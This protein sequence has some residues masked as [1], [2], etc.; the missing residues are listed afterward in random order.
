MKLQL[1]IIFSILV[2]V[3]L[4][5]CQKDS[6]TETNSGEN[7]HPQTDI[8]WPSLTDSPWPMHHGNPQSTG[9]SSTPGPSE[10]IVEWKFEVGYPIGTSI[11]F[12][13]DSTIYFG[14]DGPYLW[15]LNWDGSLKWK[16][17]FEGNY[18]LTCPPLIS[19][20]GTIY[21]GTRSNSL[22]AL[23]RDG[24]I[25][26]KF[27]ADD[28]VNHL[29]MNIG[30]D[31][32]IYFVDASFWLY[33]VSPEGNLKWKT[34]GDYKFQ[35]I[36]TSGIALSPNGDM[37]YL[38]C[39]GTS[40]SDTSTGLVAV[41]SDGTVNWLFYSFP[42]YGT[43]LI[44]NDGNI[45]FGARKSPDPA[46]PDNANKRGLF[47]LTPEGKLR[48]QY[49]A[50]VGPMMD[51]TMDYDGNIYF[52]TGDQPSLFALIA[53]DNEGNLRW[54]YSDKN[55]MPVV[56]SLICDCEGNIYFASQSNRLFSFNSKGDLRWEMPIY[57]VYWISPMLMNGRIILGT[58]TDEFGKTLYVIK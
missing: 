5:F 24:S 23:R 4:F 40:E 52:A 14:S 55:I 25:K 35:G 41:N 30:L 10:G 3:A 8:S 48:W 27:R 31:G 12:D 51:P 45:Y 43:P 44:D 20:D 42:A 47:S 33:A 56:S 21:I 34:G 6:P 32:T 49:S 17:Q 11:V 16:V 54:K 7:S 36:E 58:G 39:L 13:S 19:S 26:W 9:R 46:I 37:L 18:E 57:D 50:N 28:W 2:F 38:G 22:Y 29:G 1:T 53:L 15:A